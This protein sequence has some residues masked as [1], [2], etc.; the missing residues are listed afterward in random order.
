MNLFQTFTDLK[1]PLNIA[2]YVGMFSP[3]Q[4]E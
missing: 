2:A 1:Q 3:G 4:G